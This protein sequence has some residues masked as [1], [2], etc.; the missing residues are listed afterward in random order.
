MTAGGIVLAYN[1]PGVQQLKLPRDV[2]SG[3]FLGTIRTW[4]DPFLYLQMWCRKLPQ[5]LMLSA[6][7][8]KLVLVIDTNAIAGF[9]LKML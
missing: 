7:I 8:I 2:Y 1:L 5:Q 3:M 9:Q 6:L 4:N